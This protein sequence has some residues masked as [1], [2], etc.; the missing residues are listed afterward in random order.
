MNQNICPVCGWPNLEEP[1]VQSFEICPSCGTEFGHTDAYRSHDELRFE[2]IRRGLR[3]HATWVAPPSA[4]NPRT[5]LLE[6][7]VP[8]GPADRG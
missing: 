2:W 8:S 1:P 4:W 7:C 5:Q 6:H 3:W